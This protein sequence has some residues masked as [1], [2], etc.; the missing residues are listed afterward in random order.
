LIAEKISAYR[1][2]GLDDLKDQLARDSVA[3]AEEVEA[4][5]TAVARADALRARWPKA[6]AEIA[7][8]GGQGFVLVRVEAIGP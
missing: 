8:R 4:A 5:T 3:A 1:A 6:V 2:Q 7:P